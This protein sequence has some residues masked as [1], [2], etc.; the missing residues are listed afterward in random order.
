MVTDVGTFPPHPPQCAHWG[1]LSP[2]RGLCGGY[3]AVGASKAPPPTKET[4]ILL[5]SIILVQPNKGVDGE[6]K[7]HEIL[8]VPMQVK[9]RPV[10]MKRQAIM[11]V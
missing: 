9:Y 11:T 4:I 6:G 10:L 5:P 3:A 2:R 7:G 1:T 8:Q